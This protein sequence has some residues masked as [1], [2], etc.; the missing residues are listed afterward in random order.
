METVDYKLAS[1]EDIEMIV[2]QRIIFS[3]LL[4]GKQDAAIEKNL[5][6]NMTAY[7]RRELNKTYIVWYAEID[8]K[9]VSIGGLGIRTQPGNIKNPSGVWGY[10]MSIYTDPGHRKKGYSTNILNHLIATAKEMGCTAFELHATP[11]GAPVYEKNG[12]LKH[13]EPT[14][15]KFI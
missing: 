5:R 12:F 4:A 3:D 1:E 2:D 14:Y 15:R 10:I 8:N 11:E 7:F 9:V 13:N 6:E